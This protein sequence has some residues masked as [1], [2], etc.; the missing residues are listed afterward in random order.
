MIPA[1]A[2]SGDGSCFLSALSQSFGRSWLAITIELAIVIIDVFV[3]TQV[4]NWNEQRI[5]NLETRR[6]LTQLKPE[7]AV[8]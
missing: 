5:E 3:G 1:K 6:L 8:L 7:V 4:A 2:R